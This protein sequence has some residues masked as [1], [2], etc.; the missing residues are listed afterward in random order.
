M[1]IYNNNIVPL[2]FLDETSTIDI[3]QLNIKDICSL[4]ARIDQTYEI[5]KTRKEKL[6]DAMNLKFG[7][8]AFDK[9]QS[10]GKTTGTTHFV[11]NGYKITAKIG[12]KIQWDQDKL[13]D[14]LEQL[15]AEQKALCVKTNYSILNGFIGNIIK[16][17]TFY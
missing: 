16:K 14:L 5:T 2:S 6:E 7:S 12:K 8:V 17:L 4:A 9:L 11:D 3:S 10:E 1:D 13:V 15:P